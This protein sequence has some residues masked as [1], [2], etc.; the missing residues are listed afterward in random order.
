MKADLAMD[1]PRGQEDSFSAAFDALDDPDKYWLEIKIMAQH[2][3]EMFIDI[4]DSLEEDE[5]HVMKAHIEDYD[6]I[7][8]DM[9]YAKPSNI[10]GHISR[11]KV[12]EHLKEVFAKHNLDC[13]VLIKRIPKQEAIL[14]KGPSHFDIVTHR[15]NKQGL[16]G[17]SSQDGLEIIVDV[18]EHPD[19]L[20]ELCHTLKE[21]HLDVTNADIDDNDDT[22]RIKASIFARQ[23]FRRMKDAAIAKQG[24]PTDKDGSP[25]K[26]KL[27]TAD[28]LRK[29]VERS[30]TKTLKS[31][32]VSGRIEINTYIDGGDIMSTPLIRTLQRTKSTES[33]PGSYNSRY[34][35]NPDD[36]DGDSLEPQAAKS[37]KP[38]IDVNEEP[39]NENQN[40]DGIKL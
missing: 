19:I 31:H 2:D 13:E 17:A 24:G 14:H 8:M 1:R 32:K 5:L 3:P 18:Q 21:C 10:Y 27:P 20:R 36:D 35:S 28:E 6:D 29:I 30:L 33:T 40:D 39:N 4:V 34:L 25:I 12:K 16:M 23:N 7:D 37:P 22:H 26:V 9:F 15:A 11:K 38:K